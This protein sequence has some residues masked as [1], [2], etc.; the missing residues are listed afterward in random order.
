MLDDAPKAV[1]MGCNQYPFPLLDLG[2]YFF[3]PKGQSSGN[4]VLQTL[5]GGQLILSE[6]CIS[7]I[8]TDV[9]VEGMV[10]LHWRWWDIIGA[11]PDLYLGLAILGSS[12]CLIEASQ[13][14]IVSLIKVPDPHH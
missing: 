1:A 8:L 10:G 6:V 7:A 2:N 4:S 13:T 11:P 12:F 14:P 5:I 3:I 9:A